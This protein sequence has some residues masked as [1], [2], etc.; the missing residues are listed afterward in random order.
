MTR[1]FEG[2]N[3]QDAVKKACLQLNL[4]A[5]RL[6]Y[7]IV[8]E[9]TR[10][11]FG[12][13]GGKTAVIRVTV[14]EKESSDFVKE[15]ID[16][17]F[18]EHI[19]KEVV[20]AAPADREPELAKVVTKDEIPPLQPPSLAP[21]AKFE[22]EE[23]KDTTVP[24]I[25]LEKV[26]KTLTEI[27]ALMD[28]SVKSIEGSLESSDY[29]LVIEEQGEQTMLVSRK[30]E[31]LDALQ[32]LINKLY[33]VRGGRVYVDCGGFRSRHENNIKRLALKLG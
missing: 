31:V 6:H 22:K 33:G 8:R 19:K 12:L 10:K 20:A 3:V 18:S 24:T 13:L 9:E 15:L 2:K 25:D 30:G 23:I 28:V 29:H 4:S 27:L 32:Y 11:I 5:E 14:E 17:A 26:K 16:S 7:E 1:D 21:P